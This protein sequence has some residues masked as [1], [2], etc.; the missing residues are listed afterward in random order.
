MRMKRIAVFALALLLAF[1][2]GGTLYAQQSSPSS[3]VEFTIVAFVPQI[4]DFS[5]GFSAGRAALLEGYFSGSDAAADDPGSGGAAEATRF[6]IREGSLISLGNASL[7]SNVRGTYTISAYSVNGGYLVPDL[8]GTGV[9]G[10]PYQLLLGDQ[11]ARSLG[12]TYYFSA[13]GKTLREGRSYEVAL[14]I[15]DVPAGTPAGAFTD[16]LV[17]SISAN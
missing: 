4:L 5:L 12:G 7:H 13:S 11:S 6:Q 17:F 3:S 16:Q 15:A 10:I 2:A 1:A 8:I 14:A 9:P